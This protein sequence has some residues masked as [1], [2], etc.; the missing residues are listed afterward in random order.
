M[1][2]LD[3]VAILGTG[4]TGFSFLMLFIGYK[5]TSDVQ[6]KILDTS[7]L[8]FEP[9][10]LKI[11]EEMAGKQLNNTR[12]FL[13]FTLLFLMAGLA[14]LIHR[15]EAEVVLSL[16]PVEAEHP[17]I[18]YI[19]NRKITLDENGKGL[20]V[21]K[22]EHALNIDN[23]TVFSKLSKLEAKLSASTTSENA[24]IQQLSDNTNDSG[25]GD[26]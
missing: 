13:G 21:L 16:T 25:F 26:F 1:D 10:K 2:N 9:E 24:L 4:A 23:S 3:V 19:Q 7:L 5:L 12:I 14:I 15:P 11:W 17:T 18:L 8:D 22:D 20:I 6:N